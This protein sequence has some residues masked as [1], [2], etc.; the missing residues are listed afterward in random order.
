[1]AHVH[2]HIIII[3]RRIGLEPGGNHSKVLAWVYTNEPAKL[4][5][6]PVLNMSAL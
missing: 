2:P 3:E 6:L 5:I 1:M 4:Q